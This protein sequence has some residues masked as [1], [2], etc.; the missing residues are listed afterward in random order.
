MAH[1]LF[2][3]VVVTCSLVPWQRGLYK[4][5]STTGSGFELGHQ[6]T[7]EVF[8]RSPAHS[9]MSSSQPTGYWITDQPAGPQKD[10]QQNIPYI[11]N[12]TEVLLIIYFIWIA[13]MVGLANWGSPHQTFLI[14]ADHVEFGVTSEAICQWFSRVT[15]SRVNIT[16][17]SH[18]EWPKNRYSW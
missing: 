6:D 7:A 18:H 5:L 10:S 2:L 1:G 14:L 15:K 8:K 9:N 3:L 12:V 17:K 11:G 16:G 4:P 13:L